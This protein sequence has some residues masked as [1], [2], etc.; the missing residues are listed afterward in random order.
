MSLSGEF[1]S[2]VIH[3]VNDLE[4]REIA[5]N[6][7]HGVRSFARGGWAPRT[8]NELRDMV[9]EPR[10]WISSRSRALHA[11][12]AATH[13]DWWNGFE[14]AA[15]HARQAV[16]FAILDSLEGELG[17]DDEDNMLFWAS[18]HASM[19]VEKAWQDMRLADCLFS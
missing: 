1:A 12:R 5:L 2:R 15:R 10:G 11:V 19:R 3:F 13:K 9:P 6:V 17:K 8:L 16:A 18:Y 4:K 14:G 7:I